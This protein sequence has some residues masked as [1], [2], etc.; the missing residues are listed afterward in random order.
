MGGWIDRLVG[1]WIIFLYLDYNP[2]SHEVWADLGK[3]TSFALL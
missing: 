2:T 3:R 1:D